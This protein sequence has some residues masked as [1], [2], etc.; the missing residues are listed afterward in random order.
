MAFRL[1][2]QAPPRQASYSQPTQPS[3]LEVPFAESRQQQDDDS[4][5][6]VLFSPLQPPSTTHTHTR[7]DSTDHTPR[8]AGL[9]R[10]SDFGSWNQS[11]NVGDEDLD[12]ALEEDATEL[13]SLDDGLHAFSDSNLTDLSPPVLPTH[14]GLGSFHVSNQLVQD[15]LWR[16]EQY[17]PHRR[18]SITHRRRSS[19]QWHLETVQEREID[20]AEHER[21][22]RIEKWRMEQGRILLQE[23]ERETRRHQRRNSRSSLATWRSGTEVL[24]SISETRAMDTTASS[25]TPSVEGDSNSEESFWRRITRR[26]IRDLIGIDDSLLSVILGESLVETGDT[27]TP[28]HEPEAAQ[29]EDIDR[30]MKDMKTMPGDNDIWKDRLLQRI[31]RELGSLVH[32]IWEHPSAFSTY[33]RSGESPADFYAGIPVSR[34]ETEPQPRTPVQFTSDSSNI[35]SS[36]FS[37]H[38]TPTLRDPAT[39]KHASQWGI[40]EDDIAPDA[41]VGSEP[42][43]SVV[44]ENAT[45]E[46]LSESAR[47]QREHEYW[48]RELDVRMVFRYLRNRFRRG[49]SNA[50]AGGHRT[51]STLSVDQDASH[52]AAVIR[53]H[54]P[55]VARAYARS[56]ARNQAQFERQLQLRTQSHGII[57]GGSP[58]SPIARYHFRRPSSSCASQSTKVSAK[59]TLVGSGS[60]R[61]YWDIGGSVG[62]GS[63]VVSVGGPAGV[64]AWGE[65]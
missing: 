4:K 34:S 16:Y 37:P 9:S 17:N 29:P 28:E 33:M 50:G 64:G 38:F 39:A 46:P 41:V 3:A 31:A 45:E 47:L 19:A 14:D 62:S 35:F 12:E 65:V 6:W 51:N 11:E 23:L 8:T 63:A 60:S 44:C 7:T 27:T 1:P 32:Q 26:V 25:E 56:Q 57:S 55:L 40:E 49:D 30:E 54:H 59:R 43:E 36:T 58:S 10:L 21:W 2:A 5:E 42:V 24:D 20:D 52:R 15:Q 13:D 61:N 18:G 22:Q 53:Q 48:E